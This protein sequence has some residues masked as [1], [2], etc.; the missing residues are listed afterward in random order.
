MATNSLLL[1]PLKNWIWAESIA[2]PIEYKRKCM[3]SS[4]PGLLRLEKT[5]H[6]LPWSCGTF[7]PVE[8]DF[9]VKSVTLRL[10]IVKKPN[11]GKQM[12]DQTAWFQTGLSTSCEW[13]S[14]QIGFQ[15]QVL[16]GCHFKRDPKLSIWTYRTMGDKKWSY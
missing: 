3:G 8:D 7:I 10:H 1:F 16:Y 11:V 2:W 9:H 12:P 4:I 5:L 15:P 14:L 6:L 13:R